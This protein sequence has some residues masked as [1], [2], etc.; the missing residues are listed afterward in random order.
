[1][2]SAVQ[3][4]LSLIYT[5]CVKGN[6]VNLAFI[7]WGYSYGLRQNKKCITYSNIMD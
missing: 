3:F 2:E 6:Q 1:M 5:P 4:Y 7:I